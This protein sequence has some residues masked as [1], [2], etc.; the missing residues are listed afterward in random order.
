VNPELRQLAALFLRLGLTSFGGPAA[1][2]AF[3][4]EEVVRRRRWIDDR[5]FLELV[6]AANLV[7]GPNSTEV[8][9]HIGRIRAGRPGLL[10]AGAAFILPAFCLVLALAAVYQQVGTTPNALAIMAGITPVIVV[11]VGDAVWQLGRSTLRGPLAAAVALASTAAALRGAH[12]LAILAVAGLVM[13]AWRSAGRAASSLCGLAALTLGPGAVSASGAVPA[14]GG[15]PVTL[16]ALTLFFLKV[17]SV[18]YGS[19]YVLM[20]FLKTDLV[21]RRGWL[22]TQQLLDA[23]AIG[24]ITPGPLFTTATWIGYLLG[25]VA[26]AV[27][28][29]VA[30][31]APGF[32]CVG[33]TAPFL[34]RLRQSTRLSALLEGVVLASLG[35][36]AAVTLQLAATTLTTPFRSTLAAIAAAALV[37]KRPNPTVLMAGGAVVGWLA[38]ARLQ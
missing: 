1:H 27:L 19:G 15:T 16:T 37:W 31:F 14:L 3:M 9:M 25:G 30:I 26:G 8:A 17:G 22:T 10:V 12:E 13:L 35:L 2:L 21:E 33:L 28:A 6:A 20:A 5:A 32:L 38:R 11:I 18:L 7:P 4:R 29:T 23:I 24:Q 36:M 34:D